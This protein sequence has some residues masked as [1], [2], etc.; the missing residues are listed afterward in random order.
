M[1][2]SD[3]FESLS[4][5]PR[6]YEVFVDRKVIYTTTNKPDAVARGKAWLGD[7]AR[8]ALFTRCRYV[9]HQDGIEKVYCTAHDRDWEV[10]HDVDIGSRPV[11]SAS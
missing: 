3:T 2:S 4:V 1:S 5:G 8:K 10:T 11:G 9:L 6:V 7:F